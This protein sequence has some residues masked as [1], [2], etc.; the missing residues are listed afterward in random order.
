MSHDLLVFGVSNVWANTAIAVGALI[1]AYVFVIWLAALLWTWRD[2]RSRTHDVISQ[3][4]CVALVFFLNLPGLLLYLILRP[5]LTMMERAELEMEIDAFSREA[6]MQMRCPDCE[7]EVQDSFAACP[8]CRASLASPCRECGRNL[9]VSWVMCPY[10]LAPRA[11][12]ERIAEAPPALA[13]PRGTLF[14]AWR[15]PGRPKPTETAAVTVHRN[16]G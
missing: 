10:C 1:A 4:I 9:S 6:A 13:A 11:E 2:I 7:R 14:R 16:G 5:Q 15:N 3:V 12:E 8:Y